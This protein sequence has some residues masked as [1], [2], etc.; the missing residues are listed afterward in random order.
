MKFDDILETLESNDKILDFKLYKSQIPMYLVIRFT[1]LQSIINKEYNLTNPH[2]KEQKKSLLKTIVYI[3]KTLQSNLFFAPKKN[4]YIFSSDILNVLNKGKYQNRLYND[5]YQFT[6]EQSQLFEISS[7]FNYKSPKHSR[8]YSLD[9]ILLLGKFCSIFGK[10]NEKDK[11]TIEKFLRYLSNIVELNDTQLKALQ[12]LLVKQSKYLYI[13]YFFYKAFLKIKKPKVL[14]L[15]CAHYG[16]Y[17]PLIKI[18]K[19]LNITI[20]EYQHGYIGLAHPAYNFLPSIHDKIKGYFPEFFLT[21][22][23]YWS[24]RVR[25]PGDKIE[26]GLSSL[27]KRLENKTSTSKKDKNILFISGGTTYTSLSVLI[28]SVYEELNAMG[29]EI[30]LRPH[31]SEVSALKKRYSSLISK[32][33]SLDTNSL[34]DSLNTFE[35]VISMEVSTVLFEAVCF[36][37]KVYLMN[38]EY[39]NFYE[40]Q[41]PFIGFNDSSSLIKFIKENKTIDHSSSYFW[42]MNWKTNYNKFLDMLN[43]RKA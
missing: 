5:L 27:V 3:L 22:G 39:T 37:K 4:I 33:V 42:E 36:T 7:D 1:L 9:M 28:E 6:N 34:Y 15:D 20:S 40:P 8:V 16:V 38:T 14:I 30:F 10:R 23:K 11:K 29:Y 2:V 13:Q 19:E 21:H 43:I 18:A 41:N 24:E 31:P 12:D 26:I 17:L 32:G 25:I 35:I